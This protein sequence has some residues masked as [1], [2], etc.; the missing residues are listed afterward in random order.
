MANKLFYDQGR[1]TKNARFGRELVFGDEIAGHIKQ[2]E[3]AKKKL[4][5]DR[6]QGRQGIRGRIE[7]TEI[8]VFSLI[9]SCWDR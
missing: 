2:F 7:R 5:G 4:L 8:A 3:E 9:R 1:T 6:G